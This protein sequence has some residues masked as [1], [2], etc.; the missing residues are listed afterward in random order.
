MLSHVLLGEVNRVQVHD[1]LILDGAWPRDDFHD[2]MR[3]V[4][5]TFEVD[6]IKNLEQAGFGVDQHEEMRL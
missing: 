6:T 4:M 1:V 3:L 5:P 2:I